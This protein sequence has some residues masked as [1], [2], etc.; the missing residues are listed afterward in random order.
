MVHRWSTIA[1]PHCSVYC[2]CA[3]SLMQN[4]FSYALDTIDSLCILLS[5]LLVDLLEE[6]IQL[7]NILV[8]THST[9]EKP[10]FSAA[11]QRTRH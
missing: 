2:V 3:D 11:S 4:D 1:A 10:D 6:S 7:L 8:R 5:K 9:V